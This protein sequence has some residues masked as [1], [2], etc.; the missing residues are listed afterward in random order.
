MKR[1]LL[2]FCL[3]FFVGCATLPNRDK[4]QTVS[5]QKHNWPVES[6]TYKRCCGQEW[7]WALFGNDN[8]GVTPWFRDEQWGYWKWWLRNRTHN[9]NWYVVGYAYWEEG[10]PYSSWNTD[11]LEYK[12]IIGND[13]ADDDTWGFK[14]R[15]LKPKHRSWLAWR[16]FVAL[17]TK[18]F[19]IWWG[20]KR[21]GQK[22]AS[23]EFGR[24]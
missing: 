6:W 12:K 11:H 5:V 8:D 22:A 10:N 23:I 16:P 15:L 24:E 9:W 14:L 4:W 7:A 17:N 20:W 3:V 1:F 13:P 18:Y 2:V 21:R 19:R